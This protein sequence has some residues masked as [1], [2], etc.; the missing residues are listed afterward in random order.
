MNNLT[1]TSF[2]LSRPYWLSI[3]A[4]IIDRLGTENNV[5]ENTFDNIQATVNPY[6]IAY[7]QNKEVGVIKLVCL[8]LIQMGFIRV[9]DS[10]L[11][12]VTYFSNTSHLEPIEQLQHK[13]NL[14]QW[15]ADIFTPDWQPVDLI[16]AGRITR[17]LAT[18]NPTTTITRGKTI[19][20]QLNSL[21]AEIILVLQIT[22][23]SSQAIDLCLQLY[24]GGDSNYLPAGL[25]VEI[26]D[27]NQSCMSARAKDTDD[28]MQL[29]FTCQQGEQFAIAMQLEGVSIVEYFSV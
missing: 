11:E 1:N 9:R 12:V 5:W 22:Q 29:E 26:I 20:W 27:E 6:E 18:A 8:E 3:Y 4:E 16:L 7:L 23:Q 24:P 15:F 25:L 13:V 21:S 17:S 2:L 19:Q 10:Q 28:W 14:R